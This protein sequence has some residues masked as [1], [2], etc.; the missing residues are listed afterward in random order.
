V[1]VL[2][3]KRKFLILCN[4]TLKKIKDMDIK[5][6][7]EDKTFYFKENEFI[8]KSGCS[9]VDCSD[10][11]FGKILFVMDRLDKARKMNA[12]DNVDLQIILDGI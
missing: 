12:I 2:S 9:V 6:L 5:K 10:E 7:K 3:K 1:D 4:E 8:I 11:D